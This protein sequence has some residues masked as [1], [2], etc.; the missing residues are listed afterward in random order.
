MNQ[1]FLVR[2]R[3]SR[4]NTAIAGPVFFLG[5]LGGI[6]VPAYQDYTI[7]SQ[8]V[9]G[10][11]IAGEVKVAVAESFAATGQWPKDLRALNYPSAPRGKYVN[12]VAVNRGTVIIRYSHAAHPN[13][14]RKQLT[15]RPTVTADGISWR[16][17]YRPDLGIDPETGA[18]SPPATDIEPKYLPSTCRN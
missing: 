8:V 15:L 5:I 4:G 14:H 12:F 10:I 11:N 18:A 16:C 9:E 6:A 17:G 1:R 2:R 3:L 13:L 7:R